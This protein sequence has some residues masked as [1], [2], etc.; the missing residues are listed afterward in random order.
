[1]AQALM[2][3]GGP[4][5]PA[6]DAVQ[7]AFLLCR[8]LM[9]A[10]HLAPVRNWPAWLR[11]TTVHEVLQLKRKAEPVG[12][13]PEAHRLVHVVPKPGGSVLDREGIRRTLPL[14]RVRRRRP[15]PPGR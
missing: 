6:D 9:H 5:A 1:M 15:L 10:T 2:V 13:D 4:R 14:V 12:F 11:T 7:E 8:E 3:S